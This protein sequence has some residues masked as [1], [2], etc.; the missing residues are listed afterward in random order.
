MKLGNM[1]G[2]IYDVENWGFNVELSGWLGGHKSS[3][4]KSVVF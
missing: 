4:C 1:A 3:Q 2:K